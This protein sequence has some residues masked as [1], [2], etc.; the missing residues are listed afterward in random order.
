MRKPPC[1]TIALA[2]LLAAGSVQALT[3]GHFHSARFGDSADQTATA[4]AADVDGNMY[5]TGYFSGSIDFGGDMLTSAG[6][7]DIFLAKFD[8][9]GAYQ[10]S[11]RFGNEA[12][13]RGTGVATDSEGN[14]Y[15]TGHF[16]DAVNFGGGNLLSSGS[17][18]IYLAKFSSA[19]TLIYAKRYGNFD[20]QRGGMVAI[21]PN[22]DVILAGF[23]G[24]RVNFGGGNLV[25]GGGWD[26]YVVQL[27]PA[28]I[29]QWSHSYGDAADQRGLSAAVD[30]SGNVY[31]AGDFAGQI[32]FSGAV[33]DTLTSA[34][35]TDIFLARFD[36]SG[37]NQWAEGFGNG[38]L[39]A[40][41]GV[42]TDPSGNVCLTGVFQGTVD[43]GGGGVAAGGP[44]DVFVAKYDPAGTNMWTR[45]FN[46]FVGAGNAITT[47]ADGGVYVAG[48]FSGTADFGEGVVNA[49][50]ANDIFVAK[51]ASDG[52]YE[53]SLIAGDEDDQGAVAITDHQGALHV[54][55][56]LAGAADFGG[57]EIT[58][59][60]GDDAFFATLSEF[61]AQPVL[62]SIVDVPNDQGRKVRIHF[63]RSGHDDSTSPTP[64][65]GYEIYRRDDT[66][67]AAVA[68]PG[69]TA[70]RRQVEDLGWV[71]AGT[72]PAHGVSDYLTD[73]STDADST[74][75]AGQYYTSLFI[76]AATGQPLTYFDSPPDSGY[77][78]DNVSPPP[79]AN[80]SLSDGLL[81]WGRSTAP[82]FDHFTVYG[83]NGTEFTSAV[84]I[85]QTR[86]TQMNV[87][88][89]PYARFFVTASDSAGNEGGPGSTG[90]ATDAGGTTPRLDLS[91][92][93]YP[94]PFNPLTTIHYT[95]PSNGLV[96]LQI[97]D[98]RGAQVAAPVNMER[99]AGAYTA[100]WNG[101]DDSG[102]AVSSG[103]Y[104]ARL[105]H[106]SG[107][108]VLKLVL[109]K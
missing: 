90:T 50:G 94:N 46:T 76:R 10:W 17:N 105:S 55:G 58:S 14:V 89:M 16:M 27:S 74:I 20:D 70:S 35:G 96:T 9:S 101:R 51:L 103:V 66:G 83:A 39:Q 24:G 11:K 8:A 71:F 65:T 25:N 12:E 22:D 31:L 73:V 92:A 48:T 18:D 15:I 33:T 38:Q 104:F 60:G 42:A 100:S 72:V 106:P 107:T 47:S 87:T 91:I 53:W 21:A 59:A 93:S 63:T 64:V 13:Q 26:V 4:V 23:F 77:S 82:D 30:A 6:S 57:G 43:F 54:A 28:G 75:A 5:V 67:A 49:A 102:R 52:S 32:N 62:R 99:A 109:L 3:P 56:S 80:V 108:R 41:Y 44:V 69:A 37:V 78:L 86:M 61:A 40:G 1:T 7:N 97:F 45:Q 84:T 36:A 29:T 95:V 68:T 79:P 81:S 85:D 98:A 34:G 2:V 19:G 88:D